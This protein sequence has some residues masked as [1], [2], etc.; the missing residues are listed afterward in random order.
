MDVLSDLESREMLY[1]QLARHVG[2][3]MGARAVM[4]QRA[5]TLATAGYSIDRDPLSPAWSFRFQG[6]TEGCKGAAYR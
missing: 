1:R 6:D 4:L 3:P 2:L 5:E